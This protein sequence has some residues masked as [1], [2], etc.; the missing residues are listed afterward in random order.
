MT[1][2]VRGAWYVA[3]AD[4]VRHAYYNI[5]DM[6][7]AE[8]RYVIPLDMLH[9]DYCRYWTV[10]QYQDACSMLGFSFTSSIDAY[11]ICGPVSSVHSE[12]DP[13]KE[14]FHIYSKS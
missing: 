7:L 4:P 13:C 11:I 9:F 8:R 2:I 1:D 3:V 5:D 12:T 14:L 6:Y 10:H